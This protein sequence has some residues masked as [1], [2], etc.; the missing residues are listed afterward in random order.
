MLIIG[1]VISFLLAHVCQG[2]TPPHIE[3]QKTYGTSSDD[4]LGAAVLDGNEDIWLA[5]VSAPETDSCSLYWLRVSRTGMQVFTKSLRSGSDS[6]ITD[7][8]ITGQ[9]TLFCGY[10]SMKTANYQAFLLQVSE[11]G[12]SLWYRGF[13]RQFPIQAFGLTVMRN[14]DILLVGF[15]MPTGYN[16]NAYVFRADANG[17]GKW[18]K[19]V[20]SDSLELLRAACQTQD[21]GA[22]VVGL[23]Q[24]Q[25]VNDDV[26]VLRVGESGDTVW[27]KC[28]GGPQRD[29]AWSICE[30]GF[31]TFLVAGVTSSYGSGGQDGYVIAMSGA[32]D[33]L[34]TRTYG[35]VR[36]DGFYKV[37]EA[38]AG[39]FV[40]L[41]WTK[42]FGKG[43]YD[44]YAVEIDRSGAQ[45]WSQNYGGDKDDWF[46]EGFQSKDGA[47]FFAGTTGSFGAKKTDFWLVCGNGK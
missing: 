29:A 25:D 22:V 21:D 34:W 44:G 1:I 27:S 5:G 28:I 9:G 23:S 36:D 14:S 20:G 11:L 17:Q 10:A 35:G 33:T 32:G 45:I 47:Y 24:R 43:D 19:S 26:Y 6:R 42:S 7:A 31:D 16:K 12:D 38:R 2:D 18:G 37:F 8:A 4:K 3:W 30:I 13:L 39:H 40:L 46:I 41:G 15:D